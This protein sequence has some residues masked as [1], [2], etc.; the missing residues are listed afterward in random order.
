MADLLDRARAYFRAM[1]DA[2]ADVVPDGDEACCGCC[3]GDCCDC[4]DPDCDGTC[5]DAC[6]GSP[7]RAAAVL[8]HEL[9]Q[10]ALRLVG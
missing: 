3:E 2:P 8:A 4:T 1:P 7:A 9:R 5:C 10:R 6:P